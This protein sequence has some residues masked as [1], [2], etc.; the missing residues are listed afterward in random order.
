M[1]AMQKEQKANTPFDVV[2]IGG[3]N[4]DFQV[5]GDKLPRTGET[6]TGSRLIVGSGGK[7]GNQAVAAA[8]LGANVAMVG[9]VGN[10]PR[11]IE[12]IADLRI[13]GINTDHVGV[14]GMASTGVAVI[15]T[16]LDA[17]KQIMVADG[18][19]GFYSVREVIA[20]EE[21][22]KRASCLVLQLELPLDAVSAAA[23]IGKRAGVRVILDAAPARALP[24]GFLDNIDIVRCNATEAQSHTG[25]V[26]TGCEHAIRAGRMLLERGPS[27]AIVQ[28]GADGDVLVT[29]SET[30]ALPRFDVQSVDRTGAGDAFVAALAVRSAQG[31]P[32]SEAA[33]Y[34]SAAAACATTVAGARSGLPWSDRV[35]ALLE[36]SD[37]A[38]CGME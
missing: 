7:G 18:A 36:L 23:E 5:F 30:L 25:I 29:R 6:T 33:R 2:V 9:M 1:Q 26:V 32:L 37:A 35:E 21:F 4:V 8:R 15:M 12:V 14:T 20:A 11:G 27:V 16:N 31:A 10:D 19:N 22:I 38:P 17:E 28:A 24:D 34:A 13:E 3:L